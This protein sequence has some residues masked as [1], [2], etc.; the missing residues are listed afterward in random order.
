MNSKYFSVFKV[1]LKNAIAYRAE[2]A[3]D[4]TFYMLSALVMVIVWIAVYH[5]S[6]LTSISGVTIS[7]MTVYLF[8]IGSIGFISWPGIANVL[9]SDMRSGE[10]ASS[11]IRP[12]KYPYEAF[13]RELT[14]KIIYSL[15]GTL[16]IFIIIYVIAGLHLTAMQVLMLIIEIVLAYLMINFIG[17]IIG[18]LAIYIT[19]IYGILNGI[20]WMFSLLG[21]GIM[22][23]LLYPKLIYGILML[24]PFPF[25]YFVPG[26]TFTGIIPAAQLP[27]LVAEEA[28]WALV[29]LGIAIVVWKRV[30]RD[31]NAVGV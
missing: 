20:T 26:G 11:L 1:F 30:S 15:A 10:I 6:D 17:F 21:G 2:I 8:A 18:S 3:L 13:I 4:A 12:I 14:W 22:P 23:L 28:V 31:I 29:L 16:P 7:S 19:D 25:L 24:T 5:F 9:E 27:G